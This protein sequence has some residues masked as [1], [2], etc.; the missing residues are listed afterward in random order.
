[1]IEKQSEHPLADAIV[2]YLAPTSHS[3]QKD[4]LFLEGIQV[5]NSSGKGI[6]G[7]FE[8]E[9]YFIG[10]PKFIW[11]QKLP[12]PSEIQN[13]IGTELK[14]ARTVILFSNSKEILAG[15]SISDPIKPTSVEAV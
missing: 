10:N 12:V 9:N 14:K 13:W 4:N 11:E 15:I 3:H 7:Q 6:V 8:N 5:E 1:S 2:N